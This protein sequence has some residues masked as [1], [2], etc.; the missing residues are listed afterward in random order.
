MVVRF[1]LWSLADTGTSVDELRAEE[2]AATTGAVQE[3]W[4]ADEPGERWGGF[5]VF[6]GVDAAA[7]PLPDRLRELIGKDPDVFELFDVA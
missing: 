1:V 4:F 7:A 5:A 3:V 2:L 6:P